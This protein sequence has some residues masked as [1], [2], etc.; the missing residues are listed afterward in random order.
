VAVYTASFFLRVLSRWD[1][2][3]WELIGK[4]DVENPTLVLIVL[5]PN[6]LLW[7]ALVLLGFGRWIGATAFATTGL[8]VALLYGVI[9]MGT[10]RQFG[11]SGYWAWLAGF[12]VIA[13][14]GFLRAWRRSRLIVDP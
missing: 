6:A 12:A 14:A 7:T 4:T 5:A 11:G 10:Q 3:G 1:L 2:L 9:L 13:G 8:L